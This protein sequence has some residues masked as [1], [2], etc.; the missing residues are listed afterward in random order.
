VWVVELV[1][2]FGIGQ[3]EVK[4]GLGEIDGETQPCA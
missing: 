3:L 1:G 4:H 2:D